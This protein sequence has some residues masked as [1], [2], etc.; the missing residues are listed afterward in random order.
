MSPEYAVIPSHMMEAMN[1]YVRTGD[2]SSN[3]LRAVISNDL[4]GAIGHADDS[5]ITILRSYV[6]WFYNIAP[7]VC[8]GS[9]QKM[10][11]WKGM[12]TWDWDNFNG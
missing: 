6:R 10:L 11:D 3:F 7:G 8:W 5:T 1:H 2:V 4:K 12:P 9:A